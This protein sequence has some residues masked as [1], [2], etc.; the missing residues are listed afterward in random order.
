MNRQIPGRVQGRSRVAKAP[1]RDAASVGI[2][3]GRADAPLILIVD[4][5]P[6]AL[7]MLEM[8]LGDDYGIVAAGSGPEAL[9]LLERDPTP[10]L[11]LLDVMMP[12]MDGF[13]VCTALKSWPP[14]SSIPVIFLTACNRP[15]DE[16][17]GLSVGG[18]DFIQKPFSA[19][20]LLARVRNQLRL[21]RTDRI[22]RQNNDA[23]EQ[24]VAERTEILVRQ[25]EILAR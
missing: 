10:E 8:I 17:Y 2:G 5:Q 19:P 9:A 11:I 21:A 18:V 25:S 4:D 24:A 23:L 3:R 15:E 20:G 14:T 12:G 1:L 13:E 16:E 7:L 6:D 22:L